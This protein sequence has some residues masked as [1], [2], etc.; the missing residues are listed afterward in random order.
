LVRKTV[1]LPVSYV[2]QLERAGHG[3]LSEGLRLVLEFAC[4]PS[5]GFWLTSSRAD[6]RAD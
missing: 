6:P 1:T 5:G 2:R 4:M 3:N